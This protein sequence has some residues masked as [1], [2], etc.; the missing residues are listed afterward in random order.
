MTVN[1][2]WN[3]IPPNPPISTVDLTGF[4]IWELMED[5]V[6]RT[7]ASDPFEQMGGYLKRFCGMTIYGKLENPPGERIEHIFVG[8][9]PID[10]SKIYGVSFVTSQGV[11]QKFG[12]N[13]FDLQ[14]KAIDALKTYFQSG[15]DID[16]ETL[17]RFVAV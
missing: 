7:F 14:I 3:I 11:P 17:G 15:K 8:D 16:P 6:Q 4:D 5:N 1:D 2:L 10:L 12:T 9:A 13:R